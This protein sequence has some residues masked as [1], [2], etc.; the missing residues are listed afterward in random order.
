MN[1][2]AALGPDDPDAQESIRAL[3]AEL[4]TR[5]EQL[6]RV[7][8]DLTQLVSHSAPLETPAGF[9]A[10]AAQLSP[11]QQSLL[12]IYAQVFDARALEAF[13]QAPVHQED[14]DVEFDRLPADADDA[15]VED[16][17]RRMVVTNRR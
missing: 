17:A 10:F 7:R 14:T 5:I 12:A 1:R 4:E 13:R 3:D 2:I 9:A 15:T 16:L 11:T 6:V 8:E